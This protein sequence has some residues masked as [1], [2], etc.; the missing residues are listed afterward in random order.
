MPWIAKRQSEDSMLSMRVSQLV[1]ADCKPLKRGHSAALKGVPQEEAAVSLCLLR[2]VAAKDHRHPIRQ[3][4][5]VQHSARLLTAEI[6]RDH[7]AYAHES[8][9]SSDG[10]L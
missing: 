6:C 3:Q 5:I 2:D 8:N 10:E 9:P 7:D 1:S 4:S